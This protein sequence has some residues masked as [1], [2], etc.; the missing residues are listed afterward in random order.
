MK[1][2]SLTAAV[3][4]GAIFYGPAMA[5]SATA[6]DGFKV[7][8]EAAVQRN[9]AETDITDAVTVTAKKTGYN[10]RG[11]LGYDA[12]MADS[13]LVGL[14]A[15]LG[16]GGPD[17]D[18]GGAPPRVA[19]DPGLTFDVSARAGVVVTPSMLLYGRAGYANAKLKTT[20]TE[21]SGERFLNRRKGG[22]MY[23]AGAEFALSENMALR[24]EFRRAKYGD[25]KSNQGV[26]GL[27]VRF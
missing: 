10:L 12:V 26:L 6:F 20:I 1:H 15:G 22:L 2:L 27:N 3:A 4:A 9:K 18:S 23:G 19:T 17:V 14:E 24:A 13:F 21:A 25:V 16:R 5:Q 7:G 8:V 11:Y